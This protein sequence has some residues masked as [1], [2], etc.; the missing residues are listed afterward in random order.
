MRELLSRP[1]TTT[2]RTGITPAYAGKAQIFF[3][4]LLYTPAQS[5]SKG[6]TAFLKSPSIKL[7]SYWSLT[8][9]TITISGLL[10]NRTGRML[11]PMPRLTIIVV[12]FSVYFPAS[13]FGKKPWLGAAIPPIKGSR[14]CPPWAWPLS[15]KSMFSDT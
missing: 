12:W 13:Y 8:N 11:L 3:P 15:T 5:L 6:Y 9:S 14:I 4:F 2:P 10:L 1:V 7:K